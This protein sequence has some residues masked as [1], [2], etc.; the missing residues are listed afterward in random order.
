[1]LQ[2]TGKALAS[3]KDTVAEGAG[4]ASGQAARGSPKEGG[5]GADSGKGAV[6]GVTEGARRAR[7]AAAANITQAEDHGA[8]FSFVQT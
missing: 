3:A 4:Q 2:K 1:M 8:P 6:Q 5:P 7:D